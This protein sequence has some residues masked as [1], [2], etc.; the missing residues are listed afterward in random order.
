MPALN[1][2]QRKYLRAQ[3]H[4]LDALVI[5]GKQGVTDGLVRSVAEVLDAHELLKI[6]FNEFKDQKDELLDEITRRTGADLV[7]II[8]HVAILYRQHPDEEKRK[9]VLPE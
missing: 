2:Q 5:I 6:R 8:G 9:I 3:A 4:H 7:G 1:S